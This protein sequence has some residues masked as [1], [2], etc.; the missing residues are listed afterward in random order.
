MYTFSGYARRF[1]A[2]VGKM[3][4]AV[5]AADAE[6]FVLDQCRKGRAPRTRNAA[7][8]AVRC[9]LFATTGIERSMNASIASRAG[10]SRRSTCLL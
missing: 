7:L 1:L 6:S 10:N 2:H 3:P 9:L 4:A 5:T 8:A